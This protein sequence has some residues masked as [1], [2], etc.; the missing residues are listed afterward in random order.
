MVAAVAAGERNIRYTLSQQNDNGW[1]RN[2]CISDPSK[3][4]LPG[5]A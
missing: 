1:F 3:P 5:M 4:L 2:N